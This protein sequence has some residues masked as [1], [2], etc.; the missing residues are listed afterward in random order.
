[1]DIT[2]ERDHQIIQSNNIFQTKR[3]ADSGIKEN[4]DQTRKSV[5]RHCLRQKEGLADHNQ[6]IFAPNRRRLLRLI[7]MYIINPH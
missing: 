7:K 2:K 5:A 3:T 4:R 6:D 1:M